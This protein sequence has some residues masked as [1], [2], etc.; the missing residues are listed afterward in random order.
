MNIVG[1]N[2]SQS[3]V[4]YDFVLPT[5][6]IHIDIHID[7]HRYVVDIHGYEYIFIEFHRYLGKLQ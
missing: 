5:L 1:I 4:V 3:W 6:D 2:Y 7:I